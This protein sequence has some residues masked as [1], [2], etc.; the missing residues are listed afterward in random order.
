MRPRKTLSLPIITLDKSQSGGKHEK[1]ILASDM[2]K[3]PAV[4]NPHFAIGQS[5][6]HQIAHQGRGPGRSGWLRGPRYKAQNNTLAAFTDADTIA[7][8]GASRDRRDRHS[9]SRPFG[10]DEETTTRTAR[11]RLG[12]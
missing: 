8:F 2:A 10:A 9:D 3:A 11:V 1:A 6:T 12:M 7:R 5:A 4:F